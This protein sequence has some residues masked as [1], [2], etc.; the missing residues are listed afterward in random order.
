MKKSPRRSR[1]PDSSVIRE[2]GLVPVSCPDC[3]GV[4]RQDEEGAHEYRLYICQINHRYS[5]RSL[6][7]A[8]ETQVEHVLWSACVFLKQMLFVY[9]EA[10]RTMKQWSLAERK[11]MQ[12]RMQEV[13]KQHLAIQA[14][15]QETHTME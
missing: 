8:K 6:I 10:L 12:R 3:S 11:S 1:S 4:L 13:R 2:R 7:Q 15:I 5:T 14:M 9:Q